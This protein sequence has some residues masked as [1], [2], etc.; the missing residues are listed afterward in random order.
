VFYAVSTHVE[1]LVREHLHPVFL[2]DEAHLTH[3][4][5]LEHLRIVLNYEWVSR[6]LLSLVLLGAPG[7]ARPDAAAPQPLALLAP[8]APAQHR[9]PHT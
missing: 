1:E 5:T 8:A 6:S 7:A 3:Q 9:R 4:D 2:L